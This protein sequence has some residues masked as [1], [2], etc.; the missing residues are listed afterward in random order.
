MKFRTTLILLGVFVVL[1]AVVLIFESKGK[2]AAAEKDKAEQLIDITAAD[3]RKLTL[4]KDEETITIEKDEAGEW[5]IVEPL[6]AIVFR[7]VS[8]PFDTQSRFRTQQF[9]AQSCE[10]GKKIHRQ[11]IR[12]KCRHPALT[13]LFLCSAGF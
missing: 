7:E 2:K 8:R 3:V 5:L 10:A 1:L 9:R 12:I 11:G 13:V 4:Q 6:A